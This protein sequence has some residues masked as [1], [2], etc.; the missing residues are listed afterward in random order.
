LSDENDLRENDSR[1]IQN[2]H[3]LANIITMAA[4]VLA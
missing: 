2:T 3:M 1:A 4:T